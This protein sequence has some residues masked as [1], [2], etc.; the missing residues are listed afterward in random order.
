M[1]IVLILS[2]ASLVGGV[3][4][5]LQR[6]VARR[7]ARPAGHERVGSRRL[8]RH[9]LEDHGGARTGPGRGADDLVARIE[10]GD[11]ADQA[12]SG[13]HDQRESLTGGQGQREGIG[14]TREA[15]RAAHRGVVDQAA[16]RILPLQ[17]RRIGFGN[18][19]DDVITRER[20]IR[21]AQRVQNHAKGNGQGQRSV[22]GNARQCQVDRLRR[23][24]YGADDVIPG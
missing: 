15:D 24:R 17:R 16:R 1:P 10:Q 13:R 23:Q 20:R 2:V 21:N 3:Q 6:V 8:D 7:G 18:D 5:R 11:R 19:V 22:L 9:R 4:N 14:I 12:G